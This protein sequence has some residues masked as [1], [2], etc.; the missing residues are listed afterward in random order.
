MPGLLPDRGGMLS[1][2]RCR[3][4]TALSI[5]AAAALAACTGTGTP[6][7]Q[8]TTPAPV[9]TEQAQATAIGTGQVRIGLILP[10]SAPGNAGIAATSMKNAVEMAL[11][12]VKEPNVQLLVK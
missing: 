3:A 2:A 5:A 10:L 6:L 8:F 1:G 11:A 7:D 12:D 9:P 4:R